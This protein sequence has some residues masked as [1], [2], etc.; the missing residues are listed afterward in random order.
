[1]VVSTELGAGPSEVLMLGLIARNVPIV[2]ARWVADG[3][4]ILIGGVL[5][6]SI[7]VATVIF[8]FLLAPLIKFGL[9]L[10]HYDPPHDVLIE[11]VPAA[12]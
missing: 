6:G 10:L 4:P 12:D 1:L 5:G 11:Q 9:A 2:V 8:A 3:V 7:G